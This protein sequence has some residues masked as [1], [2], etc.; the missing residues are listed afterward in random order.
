MAM[1][2]S[3]MTRVFKK[4][5]SSGIREELWNVAQRLK[6][7]NSKENFDRL[8]C[9]FCQWFIKSVETSGRL[10]EGRIVKTSEPASYGH[11]AKVID[12]VLKVLV[13]YCH[14]PDR[15]TAHKLRPWLNSAI[16]TKMMKYLK[17]LSCNESSNIS[18][19]TVEQVNEDTYHTLQ[20]L[21]HRDIEDTFDDSI[22]AVDWDDIMWRRLNRN[23][24][25]D[26]QIDES[27]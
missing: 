14:F 5:S 27:A 7:V 3:A 25:N 8:H 1:G 12:V 24:P 13:D 22:M 6:D 2:Y 15:E 21:V 17:G 11:G 19:T 9:S 20:D 16:D 4:H 23:E 26:S 10:K 18:A